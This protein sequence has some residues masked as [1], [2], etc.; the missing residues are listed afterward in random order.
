MIDTGRFII[1]SR[2]LKNPEKNESV[3]Q[4][5]DESRNQKK[6]K[7]SGDQKINEYGEPKILNRTT[8]D[9]NYYLEP[10]IYYFF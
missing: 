8:V 5:S 1:D 6:S 2:F 7:E 4:K 10:P 3:K 9:T